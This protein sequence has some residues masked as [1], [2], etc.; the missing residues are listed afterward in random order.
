[1]LSCLLFQGQTY[2]E[3]GGAVYFVNDDYIDFGDNLNYINSNTA[4][5]VAFRARFTTLDDSCVL[6]KRKTVDYKGW[7]ILFRLGASAGFGPDYGLFMEMNSSYPSP[8]QR[9]DMYFNI[10]LTSYLNE[11]HSYVF[12]FSGVP[13]IPT[14]YTLY[15]DNLAG[16]S[17]TTGNNTGA[18]GSL[19]TTV[20][21]TI[22]CAVPADSYAFFDGDIDDMYVYNRVLGRSEAS[23]YASNAIVFSGCIAG[24]NFDTYSSDGMV[25]DVSGNGIH[26]KSITGTLVTKGAHG[27][28]R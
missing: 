6:S 12:T 19:A 21:L 3:N 13:N 7:S 18:L 16:I 9:Y 14:S 4:W 25:R 5:A 27:V 23:V 28:K 17:G 26:S 15:I 8:D 11:W 2:L 24:W 1:M 10:D 20:P 22:G